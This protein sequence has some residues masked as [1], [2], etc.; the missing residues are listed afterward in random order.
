MKKGFF[1]TFEGGDGSGKSTLIKTLFETL[2]QQGHEVLV[3]REPGGT[4]CAEHIR[5]LILE[6]GKEISSKTELLLVLAAR[7]DHVEKVIQPALERGAIVLCDRFIDSTVV[8]QGYAAGQN[9]QEVELLARTVVPLLPDCTLLLD[10]P[11]SEGV[12]RR[13]KRKQVAIDKM[14]KRDLVFHEQVRSGFLALAK[15]H[16][17]RIVVLDARESVEMLFQKAFD[18]VKKVLNP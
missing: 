2:Q 10:I 15:S 8:Y 5:T 17:E 3:T 6:E 7:N 18:H 12:K 4:L 1:I 16:H 14:E 11:V 13:E 9:M